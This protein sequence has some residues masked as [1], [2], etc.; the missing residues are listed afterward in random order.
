[1]KTT[2]MLES[3]VQGI[4]R[5][6]TIEEPTDPGSI[7]AG[8]TKE[9]LFA[10]KT[11]LQPDKEVLISI[12]CYVDTIFGAVGFETD[13]PEKACEEGRKLAESTDNRFLLG[14][15]LQRFGSPQQ[16]YMAALEAYAAGD[17]EK[18]DSLVAMVETI[19]NAIEQIEK[20][21]GA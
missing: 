12:S 1:M 17:T 11:D 10:A 2:M 6:C 8:K 13:S 15:F 18:G 7:F 14:W 21:K 4:N 5:I 9:E 20:E 3:M 19:K 16:A